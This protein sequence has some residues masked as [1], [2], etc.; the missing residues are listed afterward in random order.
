MLTMNLTTTQTPPPVLGGDSFD[1]YEA[2]GRDNFED[3]LSL[4]GV[5]GDEVIFANGA[6]FDADSISLEDKLILS[7]TLGLS[8]EKLRMYDADTILG[9]LAIGKAMEA[10]QNG[11]ITGIQKDLLQNAD[12][13]L[14]QLYDCCASNTVEGDGTETI[15]VIDKFRNWVDGQSITG[16]F[17]DAELEAMLNGLDATYATD[18]VFGATVYETGVNTEGSLPEDAPLTD[19]LTTPTVRQEV[20]APV[21][22]TK[23]PEATPPAKPKNKGD[24]VAEGTAEARHDHDGDGTLDH[25]I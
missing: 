4:A 3:L 7:D 14:D 1:A 18:G 16:T 20:P 6:S 25:N 21:I 24:A 10:A 23:T 11:E 13:F 5:D 19:L 17:S 8:S 22:L 9:L 2:L 12:E 15:G